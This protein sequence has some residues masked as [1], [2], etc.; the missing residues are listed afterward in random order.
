MYIRPMVELVPGSALKEAIACAM[1]VLGATTLKVRRKEPFNS[2]QGCIERVLVIQRHYNAPRKKMELNISVP[3]GEGVAAIYCSSKHWC[4]IQTDLGAVKHFP[5][6]IDDET[7]RGKV[8]CK[9]T[10]IFIIQYPDSGNAR[11]KQWD[12]L[13][14][15]FFKKVY[16][17]LERNNVHKKSQNIS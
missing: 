2:K 8:F 3:Y 1:H 17:Y 12:V 11:R 6:I 7:F 13:Q 14:F 10:D 15:I 4:S 5:P 16:K 9:S